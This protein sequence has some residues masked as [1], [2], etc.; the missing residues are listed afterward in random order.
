MTFRNYSL[1]ALL[2]AA[3]MAF[4]GCASQ[5]KKSSS[6]RRT[7]AATETHTET[8]PMVTETEPMTTDNGGGFMMGGGD[9]H[10]VLYLPT[11]D[12]STSAL[13]LEKHSPTEVIL[14]QEFEYTLTATNLTSD[15]LEGVS[16]ADTASQGMRILGATPAADSNVGG[17]AVWGVG[18]MS[19]GESRTIRVRAV[20]DAQGTMTHCAEAT[21]NQLAC[22]TV[23]VVE[24]ALAIRCDA[25]PA[26]I[27]CDDI[28]LNIVVTN[29]G[30]GAARDVVVTST[31]SPGFTSLDGSSTVTQR[32]GTLG[33]GESRDVSF[34][35]R[36]SGS[37][38]LTHTSTVTAAGNLSADCTTT[39][40]A[41]KPNLAINKEGEARTY[42]G[43]R[44]TYT[45]TVEN[46]GDGEARDTTVTDNLP[47]GTTYVDSSPA[48][49]FDGVGNVTWALGSLAP[50]EQRT[51][52]VTVQTTRIGKIVNTARA[53][54]YCADPVSDS[55][56]TD[57]QGIPAILLEV[58]DL[59][60]PV[61]V[62][63][64]TVYVIRVT[65]QGSAPGTNIKIACNLEDTMELV[66]TSGPTRHSASGGSV[67]FG[68]YPSL[69]AGGVIEWRLTVKAVGA[70]DV[71]FG[72]QMTSDQISRTV[73]ETESTNFYQ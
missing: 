58:V 51:M 25:P 57:V 2:L 69:E 56:E 55:V 21:Y 4:T 59:E 3:V 46:N 13:M 24:P 16:V 64:T 12:R 33:A 50:G 62:G 70:G 30:S 23:R 29:T 35:V 73:D 32:I 40:V 66:T 44:V 37:G 10:A 61:P 65:N 48:G 1:V 22:V 28:N 71:R 47:A 68:A 38:Q 27:S 72:V 36:A 9:G 17:R 53:S 42:A 15:E 26:V 45:I 63:S 54:A 19:G 34:P 41:T 6:S 31:L 8:E 39:T 60:D 5:Q 7:T 52:S 11:G 67:D 49:S 14:G 18:N 43:R 20:A